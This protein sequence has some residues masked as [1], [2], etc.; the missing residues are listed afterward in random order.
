MYKRQTRRQ[1]NQTPENTTPDNQ[2]NTAT[3]SKCQTPTAISPK[4]AIMDTPSLPNDTLSDTQESPTVANLDKKFSDIIQ[5]KTLST[6]EL[7]K[8]LIRSN[9]LISQQ[10]ETI[11]SRITC[12]EN[13]TNQRI[14]KIVDSMKNMKEELY[15]SIQSQR[16]LDTKYEEQ[17]VQ[18]SRLET[19]VKSLCTDIS[20][21]EMTINQL[22]E[23]LKLTEASF[24]SN[25]S[26]INALEQYGRRE[27][28][29]IS[30]IPR[31]NNEDTDKIV[32]NITDKL[33]IDLYLDDIE[34]TH[35]T[36]PKIN[37]PIIVKFNSRRTRDEVW[38]F[39]YKLKNLKASD[40]GFDSNNSVYFNESLTEHNRSI[41]KTT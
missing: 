32:F 5:N 13:K 16:F 3:K 20:D 38:N 39:R 27:M 1:N 4:I 34:V 17:K 23:R 36:S 22:K 11:L 25:K 19:K 8:E 10:N 28:I 33:G 2:Q 18:L 9:Y 15:Q 41:F 31:K 29:N 14:E 21:K 12:L 26:D 6:D 35:R 7:L 30:G 24:L 37:A 40:F